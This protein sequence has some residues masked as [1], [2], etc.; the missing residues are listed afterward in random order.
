MR[1]SKYYDLDRYLAGE[2][3]V[4][5]LTTLLILAFIAGL[6][7]SIIV[8]ARTIGSLTVLAAFGIFFAEIFLTACF[9]SSSCKYLENRRKNALITRSSDFQRLV[10]EFRGSQNW[11][12]DMHFL[13]ITIGDFGAYIKLEFGENYVDKVNGRAAHEYRTFAESRNAKS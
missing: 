2:G 6:V 12:K 13:T 4:A 11:I 10:D 1:K 9:I 5:C 3:W 7:I 8:L